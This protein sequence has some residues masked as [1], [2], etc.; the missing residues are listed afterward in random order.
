MRENL[1]Q[2]VKDF[3]QRE[4]AALVGIAPTERLAG[5]P[6]GKRPGDRL[7]DAT[8][9]VSLAVR[10]PQTV[11]ETWGI[12]SHNPYRVYGHQFLNRL[13]HSIAYKVTLFLESEGYMA[14]PFPPTISGI[15]GAEIS[16]RHIAVAAGL[17]E[18]G[19]AGYVLTP[20]FGSRQRFVSV[21]TAAPLEGDAMYDGPSLCVPESCSFK[22][23]TECPMN[24]LDKTK[25]KT[26]QIGE[27]RIAYTW[28]D[29]LRCSWAI[30]GLTKKVGGFKEIP[31]PPVVDE[32]ALDQA[33]AL[34]DPAQIRTEIR[35]GG[36]ATYC[37]KCQAI[38][39]VGTTSWKKNLV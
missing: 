22:C 18:F 6:E 35:Q 7:K 2:T 26:C 20:Q 9:V 8:C 23:V 28:I 16:H 36:H 14:L 27:R 32:E 33:L 3:A 21:I 13:L 12:V 29:R 4:G 11:C 34:K 39:P 5:A 1:T 30:N 19:W 37:G 10:V 38:C 17:G 24:A 25:K 31:L 15:G